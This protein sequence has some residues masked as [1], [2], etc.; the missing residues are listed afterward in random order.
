MTSL[1]NRF[2]DL[3]VEYVM[4]RPRRFTINQVALGFINAIKRQA[5]KDCDQYI[6]SYSFTDTEYEDDPVRIRVNAAAGAP[7]GQLIRC[8][9][10][11][12]I[13][14]LAIALTTQ[15][16]PYGAR[17]NES[18]RDQPLY[19]GVFDNKNVPALEQSSNSSADA[20]ETITQEKRALS[21][22]S[23]DA[24]NSLLT[25][26]GSNDVEYQILFEFCGNRVPK[27]SFFIAIM[28]FMMTLAPH[29]SNDPIE[30]ASQA[31]STDSL[32][33]FVTHNTESNVPLRGFELLAILESLARYVAMK[34]NYL[35]ITFD[36]FVNS[37]SV[38]GGCVTLP[39]SSRAWCQGLREGSQ[40][41]LLGN[42]SSSSLG[43]ELT[44]K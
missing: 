9:F 41:S 15:D 6:T 20:S 22:Q 8:N 3:S 43:S 39:R 37:E 16:R 28:E 29:D 18:Y 5:I 26:P 7:E 36:F 2:A 25:I 33:I 31:T 19:I 17:F 34:R 24:K 23:L 1:N 32:W 10:L 40:H 44:Q 42:F 35:E 30:N 38:A 14:T 21:I 13:K 27:R 12:A 4:V 11:Y